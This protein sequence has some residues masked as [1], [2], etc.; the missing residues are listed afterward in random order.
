MNRPFFGRVA[1]TMHVRACATAFVLLVLALFAIPALAVTDTWTPGGSLIAPRAGHTATLLSSGKVLLV[2]GGGSPVSAELYDPATDTSSAAGSMALARTGY[3]ATLLLSGKVLVAGG[4]NSGFLASA[5][6]YDPATNTW[7]AAS[8]MASARESHTATLLPSGKVLVAGGIMNSGLVGAEL[9]DPAT[10][11]WSPAGNM[12]KARYAHAATLLS[13]GKVLVIAGA[14]PGTGTELYDPATNTWSATGNLATPRYSATATLLASGRVLVAGGFNPLAGNTAVNTAELFDPATG[15]WSTAG[16]M[17][18][19]RVTHSMTLLPSGRVLVAGGVGS[20]ARLA[21]AELYDPAT[22]AWSAAGTMASARESHT[23]T[24]LPSGR[25]LVAGGSNGS[26]GTL[27]STERYD[28]AADTWSAAGMLAAARTYHTATL[29]PSGQVLAAGGFASGVVLANAERYDPAANVWSAAGT[30]AAARYGHTATLLP[31]GRVLVAGG[32]TTGGNMLAS[33]EIY[34]PATNAWSA[35]GSMAAARHGHTAT[36]LASGKVLVAG[37][38]ST[39]NID[40][41]N[42]ELY[43]PVTNTWSAAGS[44]ATA[45]YAHTA[46]LLASGQVLAV[47]G[48]NHVAG[49]LGSAELYDPATNAWSATGYLIRN[50]QG[51]AA[52]LLPSGKV[53]VIGG[54]RN[55]DDARASTELYDPAAGMWSPGG[56]LAAAR[57]GLTATL[58]PS[59]QVLVAGGYDGSI[60]A[61]TY[62][63]SAELYDPVTNTWNAAGSMASARGIHTATLLSSGQVLFA[64]GYTTGGAAVASAELY[65]P[66]L[67][68]VAALQPG[69]SAVSTFLLQTGQLLATSPGSATVGNAAMATGFMPWRE[70]GGNSNG[71]SASNLP[72]FQVQRIDNEQMRFVRSDGSVDMTDTTFTG[73]ANALV[74]FPAGPVRVR[75]WVNGVPSAAGYSMLALNPGQP[76]APVASGGALQASVDFAAV[77]DTGTSPITGYTATASPGGATAS[78][79]A[80]CTNIVFSPLAAGN[81]T[82]TVHA[83]SAVGDGPESPASNVASV[84]LRTPVI[85]WNPAVPITYGTVLDAPQLDASASY[86]GNVVPGNFV[87]TPSF[88]AVLPAGDGQ[89]LSLTFTPDD[90]ATYAVVT[91]TAVIDVEPAPLHVINTS[92]QDKPYDGTTTATLSGGALAG[93]VPADVGSVTLTEAGT[94]A[95][96]NVGGSVAVAANDSIAGSAATNYTLIQPNGLHADITPATLTYAASP[97]TI[98]YGTMPNGLGGVVTG[99]VAGESQA[100][101]TTG[102]LSFTTTATASSEP[103]QYPIAGSGLGANNGN[104]VFVQAAGNLTALTIERAEQITLS[105]VATPNLLIPGLHSQLAASGGSGSG[106]VSYAVDSGPCNV[107]G[108]VAAATGVGA[109]VVRATKGGDA[110]YNAASAAA[111]ITVQAVAPLLAQA[112]SVGAILS[113]AQMIQLAGSDDNIGGPY[114]LTYAV[115]RAPKHGTI[116]DLDASTGALTYTP[117]TDYIGADDFTFTVASVNGV[118]QAATVT[119]AVTAPP[120]AL[121][122]GD[123]RSYARYGQVVDYVATLTNAGDAMDALSVRFTLSDGFDP[124]SLRIDCFIPGGDAVCSQDTIDPLHFTVGLQPGRTLTWLASAKVRIDAVEDSVTFGVAGDAGNAAD[125]NTLVIF[126]DGFDPTGSGGTQAAPVVEGAQAKAILEGATSMDVAAPPSIGKTPMPWLTVRDAAREVRVEGVGVADAV[127]VRLFE[128]DAGGSE[129]ASAWSV[130]RPGATL[131]LGSVAVS[132]ASPDAAV[133][134]PRAV[135]LGGAESAVSLP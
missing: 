133:A 21:S 27:A 63:A 48:S 90:T 12:V 2:G 64:G 127:L 109:C 29:L 80:P 61:G 124:D 100:T 8:P 60:T 135:V 117:A 50:R 79:T 114:P 45:R 91:K 84:A 41:A 86:D 94:F 36:L 68:P 118:S 65:D 40:L 131:E 52:T 28:P 121:L 104:Y 37:G 96:A 9:Y 98:P 76:A 130:K 122:V 18:S 30:L 111:T 70:G 39:G 26:D 119:I 78:C 46:T 43:D 73:I 62:R 72:V 97:T 132:D 123:G 35:A 99:F 88:G 24:L 101:A 14:G 7:S 34:D 55:G 75:V 93:M 15:T 69:L 54:G 82:F 74:G 110:N 47:G 31:S 108:N 20:G 87:Y 49:D 71:N 5:E 22:N 103:G 58:L 1:A 57:N 125:T 106:D 53:L 120:L 11:T 56:M 112:Q 44:L 126:R 66:G 13:S 89:T 4:Y 23:A 134:P 107:N 83:T 19:A 115:A 77:A 59:G 51:H 33:A 38:Y 85:Q 32:F 92:V 25:V 16:S 128:R 116:N 10:D 95:Q 129:R 113:T 81:Y 105:L 67:A 102:T 3:T 42:A 6:L 17:G